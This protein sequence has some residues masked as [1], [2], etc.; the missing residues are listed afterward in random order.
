LPKHALGA[1][2]VRGVSFDDDFLLIGANLDV[3]LRFQQLEVLIKRA[4]QRFGPFFRQVN[5]SGGS[6]WRDRSS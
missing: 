6:G 3:E 4:E 1:T 5:F 2:D